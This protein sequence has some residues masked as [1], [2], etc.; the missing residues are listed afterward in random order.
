MS[1]GQEWMVIYPSGNRS[2]LKVALVWDAAV[3]K[4]TIHN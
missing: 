1:N 2:E 4:K 3:N